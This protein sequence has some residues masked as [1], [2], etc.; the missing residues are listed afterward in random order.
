MSADGDGEASS[1]GNSR[2]SLG[3]PRTQLRNS[4]GPATNGTHKAAT[5]SV[6]GASRRNGKQQTHAVV[7]TTPYFG[8][9]REEVTRILIQALSDLGHHT[10]AEQ[11]SRDSGY[12]LES[13]TV[14]AFRA[15]VTKGSW[16]EVEE[17]LFGVTAA[18]GQHR[19]GAGL[20]LVEDADPDNMRFRIRQQKFLELLEQRDTRQALSVLRTE[21]TPLNQDPQ[22]VNFLSTLLMCQSADDIKA[23]AQWDGAKGQSRDDL[24]AELSSMRDAPR[25]LQMWVCS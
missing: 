8:H 9:D 12:E 5:T 22:Q 15:A 25:Q 10:A 6:N 14:A 13:P 23:K 18:H 20:L 2:A 11:V 7:P 1:N 24:L 3:D 4:Q 16:N 17:S 19:S 21:L